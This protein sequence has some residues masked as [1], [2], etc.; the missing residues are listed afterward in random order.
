MAKQLIAIV[1]LQIE[2][3]KEF[4]LVGVLIALWQ[5]HL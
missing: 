1:G 5:C 2:M 4:S 3:E